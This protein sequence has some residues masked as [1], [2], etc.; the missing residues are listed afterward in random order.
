MKKSVVPPLVINLIPIDELANKPSEL[1]QIRGHDKLTLMARRAI[2]ILW[3]NA[4][5]QG[6]KPGK[7]YTIALSKLVSPR[8]KGTVNLDETIESLMKT[9]IRMPLPGGGYRRAQ[10]LGGNDMDDPNRTTGT[11]RYRF[12]QILDEIIEQST[13]WGRIQIPEMMELSS[14]YSIPLY[15]HVSQWI[16]LYNKFSRVMELAEF[17]ALIGVEVGK[18]DVFGDLNRRVLKESLRE[19]NSLAPFNIDITP[20]KTGKKVTHLRLSWRTKSIEERKA[21][22]PQPKRLKKPASAL[23]TELPF[24]DPEDS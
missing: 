17:R 16:G 21:L 12:D 18:Y 3:H 7:T 23:Q 1:I 19:I 22:G 15:E 6:I 14:K 2:T 5:Q 9:I 4:H 11:L 8:H 24:L 20:I 13:V 10:V